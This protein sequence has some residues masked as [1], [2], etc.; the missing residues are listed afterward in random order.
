MSVRRPAS[1][2]SPSL[3]G[4]ARSHARKTIGALAAATLALLGTGSP[5]SALAAQTDDARAEQR[6]HDG[7]RLLEARDFEGAADALLESQR[8]DPQLGTLINLALCHEALGR[9]ASALHEFEVAATWA[10]ER[11]QADREAYAR[12]H[13][14]ALARRASVV[15][16]ALPPDSRGY[17][18]TIDGEPVPPG[19]WAMPLFV[20]A[21]MHAVRVTANG[22]VPAELPMAIAAGPSDQTLVVPALQ[23]APVAAPVT[24]ERVVVRERPGSDVRRPVG[25]LAGGLGL[26]ALSLSGVVLAQSGKPTPEVVAAAAAGGLMLGGGVWIFFSATPA[27]SPRTGSAGAGASASVTV[28]VSTAW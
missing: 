10:A 28:G 25:L 5:R 19:Q 26:V 22:M 24:Q 7:E 14:E 21:G 27:P 6:F 4:G 15:H 23:P 17:M 9:T 1:R 8:L 11:R 20:D 16:L 2:S 13:A 12:E 3:R 18:L